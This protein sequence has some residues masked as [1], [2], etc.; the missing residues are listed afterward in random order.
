MELSKNIQEK[1][2]LLD[3]NTYLPDDILAKVDR[4]SMAVSL[5]ARVPIL[6][7]RI[8]EFAIN[9]P[10]RLK[11]KDGANKYLLKKILYNYVPKEIIDRPKWG[12]GIPVLKW[13]HS[14][15]YYLVEKYMGREFIAEQ[16]IFDADRITQLRAAFH[17]NDTYFN[18]LV[19][20]LVVFQIWW[21]KYLNL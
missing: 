19:W 18:R 17:K 1:H 6:D 20:N 4:A 7:H 5:E 8:V 13:L 15:L 10:H 3:M 16:D 11:I 9:L 14:D 12:F 21:E 2:M